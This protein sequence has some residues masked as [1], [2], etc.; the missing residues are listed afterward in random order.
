MRTRNMFVA[1]LGALA[2]V[3]AASTGSMASEMD[4]SI[5]ISP[6]E[7]QYWDEQHVLDVPYQ[8]GGHDEQIW[9]HLTCCEPWHITD[10]PSEVWS[11]TG[12]GSGYWVDWQIGPS[13]QMEPS[14]WYPLGIV[15]VD[16]KP[17]D[18]ITFGIDLMLGGMGGPIYSNTITKH[19]TPEPSSLL[20]LGMG[21]LGTGGLL[22]RRR[23][24]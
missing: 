4:T 23:R 1:V 20:A 22:L 8:P 15:H 5:E 21:V 14:V 7:G 2:L 13:F 10:P 11:T 12:T 17:S 24:S 3:V 6:F 9:V 18:T 16:G 19:I